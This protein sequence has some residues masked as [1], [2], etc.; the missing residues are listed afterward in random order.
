MAAVL[1]RKEVH[2]EDRPKVAEVSVGTTCCAPQYQ[3]WV[4][5]L[6]GYSFEVT[7]QPGLENKAV[8]ALSRISPAVQLNQITAPA[9]IDV[10][11][12]KEETRQDPALH[13]IIR[14]IE[15]QGMEIPHYTLQQ[16]VLKFKGRLVIPSNSTLIPTI[17]HTYHDSVFGGTR[18][19]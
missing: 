3:R 6:L 5:K 12:I 13:E 4:A 9:M 19:F 7:Y 14:L 10:D 8:D 2:G 1:A 17:L 11:I 18:D 16:G 15:E